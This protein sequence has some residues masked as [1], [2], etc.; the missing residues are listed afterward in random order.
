M[1]FSE[2][3][4]YS[5]QH[6]LNC[7]NLTTKEHLVNKHCVFTLTEHLFKELGA[8]INARVTLISQWPFYHFV[9]DHSWSE[10][11]LQ[12]VCEFL[13]N[14]RK[15]SSFITGKPEQVLLSSLDRWWLWYGMYSDMN[16]QLLGFIKVLSEH[17]L[18][19]SCTQ[20]Q[21]KSLKQTHEKV[22]GGK[23][24]GLGHQQK[25]NKV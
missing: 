23:Q 17:C 25:Y 22:W 8:E 21:G 14:R 6:I 12:W 16:N 15:Q 13:H 18:F 20:S 3:A 11:T 1:F 24:L 10:K 5:L 9:S 2:G 7:Q 19:Y 4:Q